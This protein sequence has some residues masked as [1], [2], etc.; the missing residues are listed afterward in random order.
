MNTSLVLSL[1]AWLLLLQAPRGPCSGQAALAAAEPACVPQRL[2]GHQGQG[3]GG[4]PVSGGTG[5]LKDPLSRPGLQT[6]PSHHGRDG[7]G[8]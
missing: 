8:T 2:R 1:R 6:M 7:G 5:A 3:R 4:S